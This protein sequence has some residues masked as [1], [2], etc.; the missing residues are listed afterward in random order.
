MC[1]DTDTPRHP[2]TKTFI[3]IEV[4]SRGDSIHRDTFFLRD[5]VDSPISRNWLQWGCQFGRL[6]VAECISIPQWSRLHLSSQTVDCHYRFCD[7]HSCI[8]LPSPT[9]CF[10]LEPPWNNLGASCTVCKYVPDIDDLT[11]S[12]SGCFLENHS[13]SMLTAVVFMPPLPPPILF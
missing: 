13:L 3:V 1:T 8:F 12:S 4:C 10:P 2:G 9:C 7:D 6:S 5:D 11:G